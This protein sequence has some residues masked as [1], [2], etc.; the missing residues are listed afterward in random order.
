MNRRKR[1]EHLISSLRTVPILE[2]VLK[3]HQ[4]TGYLNAFKLRKKSPHQLS[5]EERLRLASGALIGMGMNL[6]LGDMTNVIHRESS[7]GRIQSFTDNYMT[8]ENLE[9]ALGR[10]ITVWN[11]RNMGRQWGPGRTISVDGRVVGAFQNNLLSKFHYRKYRTGMTVYW[12]R[13]DDGIATR[14]RPLGNQ[15]WESWHVLDELLHPLANQNLQTSCGDTQGQF[16][17][18]WALAGILGKEIL[19]RFRRPSRVLLFKPSSRNRAGLKNLRVIQWDKIE[20]A[21][22]SILRLA[23]AIKTGK[24]KASEVL[25]RW[26]FYDENGCDIAEG[27]REL[28]KVDRTEFLLRYA[29]DIDLQYFIRQACNK[30]ENWNSFHEAIFWGNGGK[31]RSNDPTRQEETLLALALLMNSIVVYNVEKYGEKLKKA[32][33]PTPVIWDNIQVLGKYQFRRSWIKGGLPSDN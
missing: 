26:H 11:E 8:R 10:L 13:R 23:E 3:V 24:L 4:F 1:H 27:L 31:L 5:E 15:E 18:L 21:L 29:R 32:R 9:A 19:T 7:I 33:A 30:E 17:G 16:L 20:R 28:G 2:A 14:V 25:R 6:G 22:P 12:F